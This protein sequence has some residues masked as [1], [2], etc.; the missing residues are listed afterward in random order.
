MTVRAG[1]G[2]G[3]EASTVRASCVGTDNSLILFYKNSESTARL[4]PLDV[5][6]AS[7]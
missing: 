6:Y 5:S 3:K 1:R 7:T 4:K 2:W